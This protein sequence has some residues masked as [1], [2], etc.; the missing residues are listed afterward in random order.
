LHPKIQRHITVFTDIDCI[1]ATHNE[2][3]EPNKA[4]I[5]VRY[6]VLEQALFQP[7]SVSVV[8]ANQQ[9]SLTAAKAGEPSAHG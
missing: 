5:E 3:P 2:A 6:L 9:S 1:T 7:Y 8:Y 4:G